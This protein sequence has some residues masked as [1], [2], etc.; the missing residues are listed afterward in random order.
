MSSTNQTVNGVSIEDIVNSQE[1]PFD[2]VQRVAFRKVKAPE[3]AILPPDPQWV[4]RFKTLKARIE[5]VLQDSNAISILAINHIGST[6]VPNL[7][8]KAVID[9]DLVLSDNTLSAEPHYVPQLEAAGF[10]FLLREPAWHEHRFFAGHEPMS[11]NLHVFGPHCAEVERHRIFRD[12]LKEHEDDR[13]LY[14]KTKMDCAAASRE[15]NE[16]MDQ[17]TARK[18]EVLRGILDRAFRGLGY[19]DEGQQH[20]VAA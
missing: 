5:T 6:S 18:Q 3:I 11:C 19:L 16:I 1:I 7:P 20:D 14:A 2:L 12:R 9:I 13:K 8:A 4:E 10:Q 17:Y 15:K